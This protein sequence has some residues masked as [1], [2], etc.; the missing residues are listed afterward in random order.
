MFLFLFCFLFTGCAGAKSTTPTTPTPDTNPPLTNEQR[1]AQQVSAMSLEEKLGQ[2][3]MIGFHG[4]ELNDELKEM[5]DKY[6]VGSI[7][8]FD[9]N[10]LNGTQVSSLNKSIQEYSI[11]QN[12]TPM[13]I[14]VDQEGGAVVRMA[15]QIKVKAPSQEEIAASD[16][17]NLAKQ[18]AYDTAQELT[19][20]GFNVNFAPVAD[21]GGLYGRTYGTDPQKVYTFVKA[22]IQGYIDGGIISVL[23]HFPGIGKSSVDLHEQEFQINTPLDVLTKED[24]YPFTRIIAELDN[25]KFMLMTSHITYTALDAEH[26]A[27]IS[28]KIN[29]ELARNTMKFTGLI[30][31]DDTEMSS[32]NQKYNYEQI[33]YHALTAGLDITLV[34]HTHQHQKSALAGMKQAVTDGKVT[35]ADI[36]SRVQKILKIKL[37]NKL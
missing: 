13:F 7:I 16:D 2:L 28:A 3:I 27:S 32:L 35:M 17:P 30:V 25:N 4:T 1:I 14:A 18:W 9:R 33:G 11:R 12:K 37:Q 22:A 19:S 24:F 34:C 5:I 20:M 8:L 29:R 23:K 26:P 36:D 10:M 21:V 31:S 6:K 15:E